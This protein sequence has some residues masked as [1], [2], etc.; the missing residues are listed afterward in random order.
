MRCLKVVL[1]M[2]AALTVSILAIGSSAPSQAGFLFNYSK[3]TDQNG[4]PP[5]YSRDNQR[6]VSKRQVNRDT[7][8]ILSHVE[9]SSN[10][11]RIAQGR[12]PTP[13]IEV[14]NL[15]RHKKCLDKNQK[16]CAKYKWDVTLNPE[17]MANA[18]EKDL[19]TAYN[20]LDMRLWW[21]TQAHLNSP[22]SLA[23]NCIVNIA[24]IDF[25][26]GNWDRN[27]LSFISPNEFCDSMPLTIPAVL[28]GIC[29]F[30]GDAIY[31]DWNSISQRLI[32]SYIHATTNYYPEYIKDVQVSLA[33]N[34]PL[35]YIHDLSYNNPLSQQASWNMAVT[36]TP[37]PQ[38]YADM[39]QS[40]TNIN[41]A[42]PAYYSIGVPG[43]YRNIPAMRYV[44]S[45]P[46][47]G[48]PS[49][50][51]PGIEALEQNKRNNSER[52][53]IFSR[54]LQW[55]SLGFF[56]FPGPQP[57]GNTGTATPFE[58]SY[59][60]AVPI[61]QV[62]NMVEIDTT[63]RGFHTIPFACTRISIIPPTTWI[64]P[65]VLIIAPQLRVFAR[66]QTEWLTVPQGR[67]IPNVNGVPIP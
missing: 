1:P 63:V 24:N 20:R 11:G 42:A 18:V 38:M 27:L 32:D 5:Y 26:A 6:L 46:L 53:G 10:L 44:L 52:E 25:Y 51:K 7:G 49:L 39:I 59:F 65:R 30:N 35:P 62:Y 61:M 43:V 15:D 28:G 48:T 14:I 41:V 13:F 56:G 50:D 36:S 33:K 40:G 3:I 4:S 66:Y 21:R 54:P 31:T 2:L 57:Q 47:G 64:E 16:N 17:S 45:A 12:P 19:S 58:Y 23:V 9:A 67:M 55:G 22:W 37:N 8:N 34:N 60:G 29:G